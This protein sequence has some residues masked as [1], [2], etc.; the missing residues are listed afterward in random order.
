MSTGAVSRAGSAAATEMREDRARADERRRPDR[1]PLREISNGV[2]GRSRVPRR[3][4]DERLRKAPLR[5]A[6]RQFDHAKRG[7]RPGYQRM[8]LSR[9][10]RSFGERF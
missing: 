1:L 8:A 4:R 2:N 5:I 3:L 10:P 9:N 6:S 7:T